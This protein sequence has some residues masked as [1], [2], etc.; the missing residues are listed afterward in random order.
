MDLEVRAM[1][2]RCGAG[3][4]LQTLLHSETDVVVLPP[5]SSLLRVWQSLSE[6]AQ[7][8]T[9]MLQLCGEGGLLTLWWALPKWSQIPLLSH[10]A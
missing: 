6:L 4:V 9:E 5:L 1:L 2:L 3:V 10:G 7:L 8:G